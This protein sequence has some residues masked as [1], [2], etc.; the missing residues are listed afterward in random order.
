VRE[1]G[2][3]SE[4][5]LVPGGGLMAH[6]TLGGHTLARH[7]GRSENYLRHRLAT[8]PDLTAASTFYDRQTAENAL[9]RV[10]HANDPR[11]IDG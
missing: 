6:E 9:A 10:L 3:E 4:C 8:E 5:L 7:V 2:S 11:C 1:T